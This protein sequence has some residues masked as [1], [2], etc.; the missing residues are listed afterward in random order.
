MITHPAHLLSPQGQLWLW[1][2]WVVL[3]P[4]PGLSPP[5]QLAPLLTPV[6]QADGAPDTPR[7]RLHLASRRLTGRQAGMPGRPFVW[8]FSLKEADFQGDAHRVCLGLHPAHP[9][10]D[11]HA[12]RWGCCSDSNPEGWSPTSAS[13]GLG[14]DGFHPPLMVI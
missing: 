10:A 13:Q 3:P 2:L 5:Q 7:R 1:T 8:L 14:M 9:V 11:M 6:L 12:G 4:L